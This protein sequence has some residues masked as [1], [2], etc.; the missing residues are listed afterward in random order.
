M[1]A[2]SQGRPTPDYVWEIRKHCAQFIDTSHP[3]WRLGGIMA[4]F[5]DVAAEMV[6][7][8]MTSEE[9]VSRSIEFDQRLVALD[10][11]AR[12]TWSYERHSVSKNDGQAIVPEGFPLVYDLYP[13][14]VIAQARQNLLL[15]RMLLSE[16]IINS[17][18][19]SQDPD[20]FLQS[21]R[22]KLTIMEMVREVVASIPPND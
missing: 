17:C 21:R 10:L 11:E 1:S 18:T 3:R 4:E 12:N 2:F 14:R 16:E 7:G 13:N 20:R 8:R 5:T 15:T 19:T 6:A 22:A 9:R